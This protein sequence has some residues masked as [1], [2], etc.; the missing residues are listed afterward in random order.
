MLLI[1][2][3]W[4]GERPESEFAYGGPAHIRRPANAAQLSDAEWAAYLFMRSNPRGV[5]SERWHHAQGCRSW[6][7]IQRHTVDHRVLSAYR[8]G[9]SPAGTR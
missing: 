2:C 1:P 7:N 6:F 9:E 8:I 4:C 5:H 3:P